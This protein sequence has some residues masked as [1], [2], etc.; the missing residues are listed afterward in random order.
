MRL[1]SFFI[2]LLGIFTLISCFEGPIGPTGE[3]GTHGEKGD[4]GEQGKVGE[5]SY[6]H[7]KYSNDGGESFTNNDGEDVGDWIGVY[8]DFQPNYSNDVKS[9]TWTKIEGEQG[10]KGDKGDVGPQGISGPQGDQGTMGL[11]GQ[12]GDKGESGEAG[13]SSYL[14]IK[15]SNDKGETFTGNNG[16]DSGTCLGTYVDNYPDD[17]NKTNSYTWVKI[18]G[19]QGTQGD[20]G[21]VGP[22]GISGP[23]GDQGTMGL[24]GP[25]GDKGEKGDPGEPFNWANVIEEN[26]IEDCIY[27]IIIFVKG[28]IYVIGTGF[29]AIYFDTIWT[30][31]HI[32]S[33]LWINDLLYSDQDFQA[34]AVKSHESLLSQYAYKVKS[35][36]WHPDYDYTTQSPDIGLL[37]IEGQ[38]DS[39]LSILPKNNVTSLQPGQPIGTCGYPGEVEAFNY[40][41]PIP[42]FKEGTISALRPYNPYENLPSPENNHFVQHNLD[43][44]GGTSGSPIFDHYG[45]VIAINNSGTE[46]LV[47]NER[48]GEPERIPSGNIGFGIRVDE[49]W[50]MIEWL[51]SSSKEVFASKVVG[52]Q[53]PL[54]FKYEPF[55]KNW[56]IENHKQ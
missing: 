7:I 10:P 24:T 28:E 15:Y 48:T 46:K 39:Y 54:I 51:N 43:L 2:I 19:E 4:T 37:L 49:V 50:D 40:I 36:L 21:D 45:Y 33:F 42:T 13:E 23:Q 31:A 9:Y 41:T 18:Q 44:S 32:S 3:Q 14:H 12:K 25:K 11:T 1:K 52:V 34:Y 29:S 16:E 20:K 56:C 30:N 8:A 53:K 47:I 55:P 6:I 38:L 26:N 22:Q 5:S 17:S 27:A 35:Y